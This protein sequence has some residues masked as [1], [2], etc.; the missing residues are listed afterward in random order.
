MKKT[1][2]I[3]LISI[4]LVVLI[5]TVFVFLK[6]EK[7]EADFTGYVFSLD[8]DGFLMAE[9]LIGEGLYDGD[10]DRLVGQAFRMSITEKTEVFDRFGDKVSFLDIGIYDEVEVWVKRPVLESYPAQAVVSR[11]RSTG[12]VFDPREGAVSVTCDD[13]DGARLEVIRA[14]EDSWFEIE[15][16]IPERPVLGAESWSRPYHVQFIGSD[17]IMIAFEDGHVI[18]TALLEFE[19]EGGRLGGEFFLVDDGPI[20]EFPLAESV[21]RELRRDFGDPDRSINTYTNIPVYAEG[22][23]I[24]AYDWEEIGVNIFILDLGHGHKM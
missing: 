22:V 14:L 7:R 6:G 18:M 19:C 5:T 12:E 2:I 17:V 15:P 13:T 11:V 8:E 21:W 1:S 4:L 3:I 24:D 23:I 20:Y 9:G 10:I 16:L